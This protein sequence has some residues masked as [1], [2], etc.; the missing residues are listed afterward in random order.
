MWK[1]VNQPGGPFQNQN[2]EIAIEI[3]SLIYLFSGLPLGC[4]IVMNTEQYQ[5]TFGRNSEKGSARKD[6]NQ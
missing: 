3:Y 5:P 4:E 2:I 1:Y 6:K